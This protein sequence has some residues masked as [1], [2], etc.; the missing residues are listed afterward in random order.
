MKQI[1]YYINIIYQ[2]DSFVPTTNT[3]ETDL[4]AKWSIIVSEIMLVDKPISN[5]FELHLSEFECEIIKNNTFQL[6]SSASIF[7]IIMIIIQL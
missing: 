1:I 4:L 3:F 6:F 2:Y 7:Y 5:L